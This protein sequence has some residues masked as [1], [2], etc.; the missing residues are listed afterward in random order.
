MI[1]WNNRTSA[2][3]TAVQYTRAVAEG[4]GVLR[5]QDCKNIADW[6]MSRHSVKVVSHRVLGEM[7]KETQAN[8]SLPLLSLTL[9]WS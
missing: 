4:A 8:S 5:C 2:E 9:D 6:S 1:C 7:V 3:L